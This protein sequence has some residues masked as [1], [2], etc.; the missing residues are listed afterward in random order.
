[1]SMAPLKSYGLSLVG[2]TIAAALLV[3]ACHGYVQF[4]AYLDHIEGGVVVSG[5]EYAASGTPLYQLQDGVPR[6]ATY[7]GPLAYLVEGLAPLLFHPSIAVSKL[8]S[9]LAL[10]ATIAIM[11]AHFFAQRQREGALSGLFYLLAG[12]LL[13]VPVSFWV[14]PDPFETLLVAA[15]VA[16][17]ANPIALGLCIGLAVNFKIHAFVY[18][19]PILVEILAARRWQR[20][21]IIAATA[22]AAFALPFLAPGI[23]LHDYLGGLFSQIGGRHPSRADLAAVLVPA[24]L[25]SLPMTYPLLT[26]KRG[27]PDRVYALAALAALALLFYPAAFPGAGSYHF[28]PL[29]PVLAEA[30]SRLKPPAWIA[31]LSTIP[32]LLLGFLAAQTVRHTMT[33]RRSWAV[34]A[35]D[36]LA[37]ARQA[38]TS[39]VQIGYGESRQSYDIAELSRAVLTLNGYP[40]QID[41]QILMELGPIG[42]DGSRR[43]ADLLARCDTERWLL[44]KGEKPFALTNF[45]YGLGPIFEA[46]FRREFLAHYHLIARDQYFDVWACARP[47][48]ALTSAD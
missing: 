38:P 26:R 21:A 10:F 32:L 12:C 3:M 34:I 47:G 41:A 42:I 31:A 2:C 36:A 29:V 17:A 7:Y 43:W 33:E 44:P 45:L 35:E 1:M 22:M 24:L 16:L 9:L 13:F 48:K 23:S 27:A 20:L 14:R 28:L 30:L 18:F 8:A 15:G 39:A 5:W 37:L 6:F 40:A 46:D 4:G 25:L 19:F 11:A